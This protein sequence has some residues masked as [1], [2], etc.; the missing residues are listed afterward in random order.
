MRRNAQTIICSA[1]EAGP[2]TAVIIIPRMGFLKYPGLIG[3]G[4]AHPKRSPPPPVKADISRSAPGTAIVPTG[5]MCGMGLSDTRPSRVAVGSP[6][7]AA[8]QPW[9]D[10]C[11]VIAKIRGIA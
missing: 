5:S 7:R 10:S 3:T 2:A 9:A 8:A 11:S 6:R 4:L 1:F